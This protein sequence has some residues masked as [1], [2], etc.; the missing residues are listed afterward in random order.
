MKY[1]VGEIAGLLGGT[2]DGNP[3]LEIDKLAKIEEGEAGSIT[4]LAN[5]KYLPF[6][7]STKASAVVVNQDFVPEKEISAALIRVKDAYLAFTTLIETYNKINSPIFRLQQ[8]TGISE[9]AYISPSAKI[10]ENCFIDTFAFIGDNAVI[11]DNVKISNNVS[12]G[13][14]V[15]IDDNTIVFPNVTLYSDIQI[16]KSCII[17]AATVIGSDGFGF[18]PDEKGEY[19]KIP[20]SGNV[21]IE[22]NV[23]IGTGVTIDR[24]TIGSTIIRKGVKI[25]NQVQIA[26][27]VE[28]GENTVIAAQSGIS[29]SSKIGKNVMIGGQVGVVGHIKIADKV[30]I[31]AKSGISKN[32]DTEGEVLRGQPAQNI[33]LQLKMEALMR[34]L[35][36]I[37]DKVKT[38]D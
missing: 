28:V 4:F 7:Y 26:H 33:K 10:G 14:G 18:A 27:N 17:H 13:D 23:E 25:D 15:S 29:G 24:A 12:V 32:I 1:K 20:Q 34:N 9:K 22:N 8:K 21:I 11:A 19:R 38:L 2:V 36:Y 5:M 3:D 30:K 35:Q 37:F 16:G 31:G 6:I